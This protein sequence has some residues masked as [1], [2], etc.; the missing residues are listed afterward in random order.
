M[1][2]LTITAA[3]VAIS[4]TAD[5]RLEIAGEPIAIG[6]TVFK[7]TGGSYNL[8][9][10][11]AVATAPA[12]SAGTNYALALS[13]AAAAGQPFAVAK[14]GASVAFGAI[15]TVNKTYYGS[16]T[17]GGIADAAPASGDFGV[18]IGTA[19]TSTTIPLT[20]HASGV[21]TA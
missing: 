18:V 10:I 17:A 12:D 14:T 3:N 8:V 16:A 15:L 1:A 19:T 5:A 9:D 4:D 7:S 6:E 11:D 2:D 20:F 13:E 21:A